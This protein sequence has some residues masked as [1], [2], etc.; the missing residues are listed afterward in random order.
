MK[1]KVYLAGGFHSDW[2]NKFHD[3]IGFEF[4]YPG[5]KG[6]TEIQEYGTWDIY[7]I[8]QCDICFAYLDKDNPSGYGLAAEI[9]YAKALNKTVILVIEPGHPKARYFEFLMCF[10]DAIYD[11]LDKAIEYLSNF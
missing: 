9:G 5:K 7:F 2:R 10:A 8:K 1:T 4:F 11:D 6:L 3:S